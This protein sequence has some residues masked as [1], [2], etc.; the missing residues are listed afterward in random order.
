MD[1]NSRLTL[2]YYKEI[3]VINAEHNISLVQHI[4]SNKVFIKKVLYQ[5]NKDLYLDILRHP[6]AGLPRLYEV[7]ECE[8]EL[9]IIEEYISGETLQEKLDRGEKL[10]FHNVSDYIIQICDCLL[11]L[12]QQNPPIIHRDIKPSNIMITP[13]DAVVLIDL[14]AAKYVNNEKEVDTTLLGTKGYAAPEQYGFGAS[15]E[16]TDIY[17]LGVLIKSLAYDLSDCPT[18]YTETFDSIIEKCTYIDP[19][20]RYNNISEIRN[21]LSKLPFLTLPSKVNNPGISSS[22]WKRILPPGYRSGNAF[23]MILATSGYAFLIWLTTTLEIKGATSAGLIIE[24]FF[25]FIMFLSLILVS[26][27]YLDLHTYLPLCK[28]QNIFVKIAGIIV[29]D[30]AAVFAVMIFMCLLLSIFT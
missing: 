22:N 1:I 4:E 10:P 15:N 26:G 17:A 25:C 5:Y 24:R 27:N 19:N 23:F 18:Q 28:S 13:G 20:Q 7:I 14:N 2:S 16:K 3:A 29:F 30:I 12:H 6:I 8:D 11:R 21:C 9:I